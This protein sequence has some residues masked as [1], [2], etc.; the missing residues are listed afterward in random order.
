M[1]ETLINKA[2]KITSNTE[3]QSKAKRNE[4]YWSSD[5]RKMKRKV[6]ARDHVECQVC[7]HQGKVTTDNLLVHH[8][9]TLEYYPSERL[10][11]DNLITVCHACHNKIHG[12][13]SQYDDEWW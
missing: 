10:N 6:L 2:K 5:W 11:E 7:K 8:I 3:Y 9:L 1:L 4:F 12:L 13:T